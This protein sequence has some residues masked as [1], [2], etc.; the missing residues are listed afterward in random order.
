MS[1][2]I[3]DPAGNLYGTTNGGGYQ[4]VGMVF[5]LSSQAGGVWAAK[6]LHNFNRSGT[7]GESPAAGV[8]MDSAGNLYGTTLGG[9][10]DNDGTVFELSPTAQGSW[11]EKILHSFDGSDGFYPDAPLIFDASGHLYGTTFLGGANAGGEV[12]E[13]IP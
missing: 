5:E 11:S 7:D 8:I 4:D 2:L 1:G 6:T 9:G 3:F 10:P 13:I 12:F